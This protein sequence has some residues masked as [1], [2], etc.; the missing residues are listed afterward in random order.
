MPGMIGL[1]I[2]PGLTG[3][4]FIS[5]TNTPIADAWKFPA[6]GDDLGALACAHEDELDRL[7]RMFDPDGLTYEEPIIRSWDKIDTLR[8]TYGLGMQTEHFCRRRGVVYREAS[9]Q[10][11]KA[12]M[13]G[14]RWAEKSDV[15]KAALSLGI[16]LPALDS[17]G[18]KDAADAVGAAIYGLAEHDPPTWAYF[19][20]LLNASRGQL[21]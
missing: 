20:S 21:L 1:D 7:F 14:E 10:K 15:V 16:E 4:A 6:C 18:R 13:T 12:Q 9:V 8:K 11:V 19:D 17:D 2:A 5:G 3:W